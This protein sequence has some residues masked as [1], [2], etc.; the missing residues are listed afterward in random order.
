MERAV[1]K[2]TQDPKNT[3]KFCPFPWYNIVID[4]NGSIRP[5]C[6]YAQ[7]GR[8]PEGYISQTEHVMPWLKDG[9]LEEIW[10][11]SQLRKLRQAF[12]DGEQPSECEMCWSEERVGIKSFRQNAISNIGK[13]VDLTVNTS[14]QPLTFD[15]KLSNVCNL[16]CRMCS[17]QAS[18]SILKEMRRLGV[19]DVDD[20]QGS[21][22]L[23]N[24]IYGTHNESIFEAWIANTVAIDLTGGEPLVSPENKKIIQRVSESKFANRISM[25]LNTNVTNFDEV[26][27]EQFKKLKKV[28]IT[29]SVDDVG[30]R[31]EYARSGSVWSTLDA[32]IRKYAACD[33]IDFLIKCTVNNYNIWYLEDLIN[34]CDEVGVR[35]E[36]DFVHEPLYLSIKHLSPSIKNLIK[37]K[38]SKS[39]F[40][41][42]KL[43]NVISF[44]DADEKDLTDDFFDHLIK[45]DANRSES[46]AEVFKEW[47]EVLDADCNEQFAAEIRGKLVEKY[48]A[49]NG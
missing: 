8:R 26:I 21:Y 4:T 27:V 6:R 28:T 46:F 7:P 48:R 14:P 2:N 47:N 38:Y 42:S 22:W 25:H 3:N 40:L 16:K 23:S 12:L 9:N 29:G 41:A 33:H 32:N 19:I 18:S 31:V 39:N 17:P 43:Y 11:G 10:N 36:F 45:Y 37:D 49:R 1:E 30:P 5:C 20:D 13:Y 34:Y 35:L 44:L 24:K 15:L